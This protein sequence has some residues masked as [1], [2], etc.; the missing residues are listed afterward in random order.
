[1]TAS[2]GTELAGVIASPTD[3]PR[4]GEV[5]LLGFGGN[6]WNVEYMALSLHRQFPSMSVAGFHYRGYRPSGGRPGAKGI[7]ADSLEIFD[8]LQAQLPA[9]QTIAIGFS[10]GSPVAAF[11]ARHR[12]IAGVILVTPFDS[13]VELARGQFPWLPVR[14]LMR[15]RLPTLEFFRE[16][17]APTAIIAAGRDSVVPPRRT[18]PLRRAAANLVLDRVIADAEHNDLYDRPEFW[19]ALGDAVEA[20]RRAGA[21]GG[22]GFCGT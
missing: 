5:L 10:I 1:V 22:S 12:A 13:L 9:T 18:E 17:S 3:G 14:W 21:Q 6:V 8:L 7:L 16:V 20:I 19:A 15:H 4:E 11:L 2:D